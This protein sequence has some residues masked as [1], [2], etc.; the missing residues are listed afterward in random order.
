[1]IKKRAL[2]GAFLYQ[3]CCSVP[4]ILTVTTCHGINFPLAC[5]AFLAAISKPPQQGTSIRTMV[6]DRMS[7]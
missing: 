6:R 3:L 7:F 2:A 1:M 5:R 4:S